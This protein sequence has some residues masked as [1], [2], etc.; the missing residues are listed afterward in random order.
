[1]SLL[2]T[3]GG[4][5]GEKIAINKVDTVFWDT[6]YIDLSLSNQA[7]LELF[8]KKVDNRSLCNYIAKDPRIY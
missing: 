3:V 8:S 1:M 6:L 2:F 4:L 5:E 7:F